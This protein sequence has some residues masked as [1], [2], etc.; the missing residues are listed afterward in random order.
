MAS[1]NKPA[2]AQTRN[3]QPKDNKKDKSQGPPKAEITVILTEKQASKYIKSAKVITAQELARADRR[4][5][6]G[7]Q[8]VSAGCHKRRCDTA[9][10]RIQR[11][12][13]VSE[14]LLVDIHRVPGTNDLENAHIAHHNPHRGHRSFGDVR[15]GHEADAP[16]PRDECHIPGAKLGAAPLPVWTLSPY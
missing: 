15:T 5:G 16:L 9:G 3:K 10:R 7:G 12:L 13:V 8:H 14:S 1:K 6:L 4:K 11:P 2:A